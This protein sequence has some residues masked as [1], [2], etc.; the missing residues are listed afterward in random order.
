MLALKPLDRSILALL[1]QNARMSF[2]EIGNQVGLS[3]P[4]VK[5]RVDRLQADGVILGFTTVVDQAAV[6]QQLEAFVECFG[7]AETD[8]ETWR[9][10]LA[11]PPEVVGAYTVAGEADALVRVRCES[12]AHLED[13]L[14]RLRKGGTVVR[15]RTSVVL[16]VVTE[17]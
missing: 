10:V 6:G 12:A 3:A 14:E 16:T 11:E 1:Q 5:R 17:R 13:T 7:Q 4:A 15:T 9:R 8:V 2:A